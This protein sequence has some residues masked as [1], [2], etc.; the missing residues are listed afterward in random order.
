MQIFL[1]IGPIGIAATIVY[2]FNIKS[3]KVNEYKDKMEAKK[4]DKWLNIWHLNETFS[5]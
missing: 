1:P 4:L 3:S 5:A 2:L